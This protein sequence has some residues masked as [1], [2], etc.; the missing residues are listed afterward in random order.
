[1]IIH[2]ETTSGQKLN[3]SVENTENAELAIKEFRNI[4]L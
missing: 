3:F 2:I 1:M 4:S